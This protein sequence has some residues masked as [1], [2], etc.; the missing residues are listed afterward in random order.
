MASPSLAEIHAQF[1]AAC[2]V[3]EKLHLFAS[4]NSPNLVGLEDTLAQA[5]EGDFTPDSLA[6]VRRVVRSSV[7][8]ALSPASIRAVL[9]PCFLEYAKYYKFPETTVNLS[10]LR[11][12]YQTF[13]ETGTPIT[14]QERNFTF[15]ATTAG[16]SNVGDGL[17]NRNYTSAWNYEIEHGHASIKTA[18]CI[19][20]IYSGATK[21]EEVF[22]FRDDPAY[23][24][25]CNR[26]GSGKVKTI[27]ALSAR[28]SQRLLSNPSF[29]LFTSAS[30]SSPYTPT[31]ITDWTVTTSLSNFALVTSDYY[32]DFEGETTPTCVRFL[33]NDGL[34]Q[35]FTVRRATFDPWTP[36][37]C[38]IAFKRESSCDGTLTITMGDQTTS[39]S[40]SAQSGWTVL[41]ITLGQKNWLRQFNATTSVMKIAL[42]SRTTGTLLV[43]DVIL[44]PMTEFDGSWYA[45]VGGATKFLRDDVFTVT[46]S[47]SADAVVNKWVAWG[48]DFSFPAASSPAQSDPT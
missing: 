8:T 44:A 6:A 43:D 1:K 2:N 14:W 9:D 47:I 12:L 21:H 27:T 3:L 16:G 41:R 38:Q 48:Y 34:T 36:Y 25:F 13:A 29:N 33:D 31:A 7:S 20:D 28:T 5:I 17:L 45:L 35:A 32:R 42:T 23:I 22:E 30:G 15:G 46:D 11:R 37:Y 26:S 19:N 39:V 40:L 24:D 10:L 4:Q 18:T